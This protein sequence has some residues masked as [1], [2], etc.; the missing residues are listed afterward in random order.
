MGDPDEEHVSAEDILTGVHAILDLAEAAAILAGPAAEG[1]VSAIE[2]F[3]GI[4]G[5]IEM[6]AETLKAMETEERGAGY[7]GTAYA[8]VYAALGH[9]LGAPSGGS[10]LNEDQ[11]KLDHEAWDKAVSGANSQMSDQKNKNRML[12]R[13]AKDGGDGSATIQ[14]IYNHLCDNSGDGDLEQAYSSLSFGS[15]ILA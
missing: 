1:V 15:P 6:V 8:S 12:L 2:P 5:I 3:S 7:R 11:T 10:S 14:N 13:I 9:S 4:I